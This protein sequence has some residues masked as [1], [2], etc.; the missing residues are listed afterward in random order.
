M[1]HYILTVEYRPSGIGSVVS[2]FINGRQLDYYYSKEEERVGGDYKKKPNE[3][4]VELTR[5]RCLIPF[6]S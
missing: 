2:S 4:R 3:F 5:L 1:T 6:L